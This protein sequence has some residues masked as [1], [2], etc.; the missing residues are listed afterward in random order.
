[1]NDTKPKILYNSI[2]DLILVIEPPIATINDLSYE[3]E[4]TVKLI[5]LHNCTNVLVDSTNVNSYPGMLDLIK[6][7]KQISS[8]PEFKKVRF[9]IVPRKMALQ[10][11]FIANLSAKRGFRFRVFDNIEVAKISLLR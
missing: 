11:K 1:M 10:I 7:S 4:E 8:T 6:F 2:D 3:I 9:A 5:K